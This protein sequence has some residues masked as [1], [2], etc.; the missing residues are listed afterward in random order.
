MDAADRPDRGRRSRHR[1]V[2]ETLC[3]ERAAGAEDQ[4]ALRAEVLSVIP[5]SRPIRSRNASGVLVNTS[6]ACDTSMWVTASLCAALTNSAFSFF[7]IGA[8]IAAGPTMPN[9][10]C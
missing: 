4:P 3:D 7:T 9:H 2:W 5:G 8:G 1:G 6:V 10:V